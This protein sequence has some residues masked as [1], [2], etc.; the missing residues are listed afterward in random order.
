[1]FIAE[2]SAVTYI[3]GLEN[4]SI[5]TGSK[6]FVRMFEG[7]GRSVIFFNHFVRSANTMFI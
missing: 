6:R 1:M 2:N 7:G 3:L 4:T 5:L